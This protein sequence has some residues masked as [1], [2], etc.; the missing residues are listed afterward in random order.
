MRALSRIWLPSVLTFAGV[1]GGRAAEPIRLHPATPHYFLFRSKPTVLVTSGEHYGAVLN[2]D[3]DYVKYLDTLA[4]DGLNNT[5]TFVGAYLENS[6]AFRIADNTL[7]PASGRFICPW[8]R[9]DTPGYANGGN[10]FDLSRWDDAYFERLKDFVAQASR[11]GIVVEV[12]LFC[13]FYG[14]SQWNLSPMNAKNNVNGLGKVGRSRVYTLDKHDGLL[15]VQEAMAR[16]VIAELKDCDNIYY[17]VMNEPYARH[18]PRNWERHMVDVI[19]AAEKLYAHKHLISRNVSN[20]KARIRAPHPAVSLFN[21][22]YAFP[23]ETVTMNYRLNKPIGD[24]ETGFHGTGDAYYR[25]EGWAFLLAG[26][27]LYNNLDYS[28]T[29]G[30][31]DGTFAYPDSQPGGGTVALRQQLGA[32]KRFMD[33]FDFIR[34]APDTG[35]V[36]GPLP[37]GVGAQ[38]L[39]E[40]GKQYAVYLHR[41]AKA[42]ADTQFPLV[43]DVPA[44][45]YRAE[46]VHPESGRIDAATEIQHAGGKLSL[47]TPLFRQDLALRLVAKP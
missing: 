15:A 1:G 19:V 43:L 44:G 7:A 29:V 40:T 47:A 37:E 4:S 8:A 46:W 32:L 39:A 42:P 12:N 9:S 2:L 3:F 17:E 25:I 36:Q 26:G 13:P 18:V 6:G 45:S 21:F 33:S 10:K 41:P 16:K 22:H 31:E 27:A 11:R 20:G 14:D 28:F 35:V 5:R 23:P 30:H 38:V 34:M 24:N